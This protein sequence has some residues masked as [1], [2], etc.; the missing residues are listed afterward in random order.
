MASMQNRQTLFIGLSSCLKAV[1]RAE[2]PP[3]VGPGNRR[4]VSIPL[5]RKHPLAVLKGPECLGVAPSPEIGK[6]KIVQCRH[7]LAGTADTILKHGQGTDVARYRSREV[8]LAPIGV[9]TMLE[10]LGNY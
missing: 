7:F 5:R 9:A 10:S 2:D 3:D 4:S 6:A 8:A 1:H